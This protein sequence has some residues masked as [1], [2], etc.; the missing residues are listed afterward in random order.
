[1]TVVNSIVHNNST[2][3]SAQRGNIAVPLIIVIVL[4]AVG[5]LA[6]TK[7]PGQR[8]DQNRNS[9][10]SGNGLIDS[11]SKTSVIYASR[12]DDN[13]TIKQVNADGTNNI[14]AATL[15]RDV[16]DIN[17]LDSKSAIYIGKSSEAVFGRGSSIEIADISSNPLA[18]RVLYEIPK[19]E[20]W[21]IDELI[22]SPDRKYIAWWEIKSPVGITDHSRYSS[23]IFIMPLTGGTKVKVS[24]E[25]D[26]VNAKQMPLFFDAQNRLYTDTVEQNPYNFYLAIRRYSTTGQ[27][28]GD[29][30]RSGEFN[31]WPRVSPDGKY[32]VYTAFDNT[33]EHTIGDPAGMARTSNLNTNS[34]R[35]INLATGEKQTISDS[36]DKAMYDSH[37]VWSHDSNGFSYSKDQVIQ[38]GPPMKRKNIGLYTY[39]LSDSEPTKVRDGVSGTIGTKREI[40]AGYDAQSGEIYYG[41]TGGSGNLGGSVSAPMLDELYKVKGG[42]TPERLAVGPGIEIIETVEKQV[43]EKI[44]LDISDSVL[45][46]KSRQLKLVSFKLPVPAPPRVPEGTNP[47]SVCEEEWQAKGYPSYE[48]C[49]ACPLYLYPVQ[50]TDVSVTIEKADVVT[51]SIPMQNQSFTVNAK[52]DGT[53]TAADGSIQRRVDYDYIAATTPAPKGGIVVNFME[54]ED[55]LYRYSERMGLNETERTDFVAFWL[56]RLP[57]SPYYFIGHFDEKAVSEKLQLSIIPKPDTLIQ[58]IMYFKPLE[59]PIAV[60]APIFPELTERLGFVAVDFSGRIDE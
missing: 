47:R 50:A 43:S 45:E 8:N 39:N 17:F 25:S 31:S 28:L 2:M 56:S 58:F 15:P 21:K 42:G 46:K 55:S 20:T 19:S 22:V 24:E 49:E 38:F 13:I 36:S 60:E 29:V 48:A 37:I 53:L 6:Y 12:Y 9:R 4:A 27:N 3:I 41:M 10:G 11:D 7:T 51:A 40:L 18:T 32:A 23:R 57:N 34:L 59:A 14:A 35:M 1:M 44:A 16:R 52:P 26:T 30:L 54:L 5:F 33:V